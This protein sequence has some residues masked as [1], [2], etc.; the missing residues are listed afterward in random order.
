ML[1]S[2]SQLVLLF[3]AGAALLPT[4]RRR[5]LAVVGTVAIGLALAALQVAP[6]AAPISFFH[7]NNGLETLGLL[8]VLWSAAR[9][10]RGLQLAAMPG[11]LVVLAASVVA[12]LGLLPVVRSIGWFTVLGVA[13]LIGAAGFALA[14]LGRLA[15][16]LEPWR[17]LDQVLL[18]RHPPPL[19]PVLPTTADMVWFAGLLAAA[20]AIC[21]AP[22]LRAVSLA[23]MIVAVTGH[24]LMRRRA[25]GSPVPFAALF[26]LFMIPV[27]TYVRAISGEANPN[28]AELV[29][30]PFSPAAEVQIFPWVWLVAWGLAA[31]WP[32]HGLVFPL[33][34]P[35]G[36]IL[37]IR[38]GAHPLPDGAEHWAPLLMPLALLGLWHAAAT[39]HDAAV[40]RRR[41]LGLLTAGAFFGIVAGGGGEAGAWWLIAS[42]LVGPWFVSGCELLGIRWGL[43]RLLWVI[44]AYGG[45]LIVEAGLTRQ[46]TWTVLLVVGVAVAGWRGTMRLYLPR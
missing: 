18:E 16:V 31:L 24:V 13:L 21:F 8:L 22:S 27:F 7:I 42:A 11:V 25:A 32:L 37:L 23:T 35:I 17:R 3:V 41:V 26:A 9:E 6:A 44:P 5:A 20:I 15:R 28:V 14:T 36:A 10:L 40:H 34:A 46:V 43:D 33:V 12:T 38:L 29:N 1:G 4:P 30:A 2:S 39:V 45:Y 19:V